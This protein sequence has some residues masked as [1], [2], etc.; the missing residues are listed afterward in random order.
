MNAEALGQEGAS[1]ARKP[2]RVQRTSNSEGPVGPAAGSASAPRSRPRF[3]NPNLSFTPAGWARLVAA[4]ASG[5]RHCG[6]PACSWGPARSSASRISGE[7]AARSSD[8]WSRAIPSGEV[9]KPNRASVPARSMA[10]ADSGGR[11]V[12]QCGH[13]D[14]PGWATAAPQPVHFRTTASTPSGVAITAFDLT[15]RVTV[16]PG[17]VLAV[18]RCSSARAIW[19]NGHSSV[20][21]SG[22]GAPQLGHSTRTGSRGRRA[23]SESGAMIQE[24]HTGPLRR[25][26]YDRAEWA[27]TEAGARATSSGTGRR[28]HPGEVTGHRPSARAAPP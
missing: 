8:C 3:P 22:R 20:A 21:R 15:I 19:Q 24:Y 6:H 7:T 26:P 12:W 11:V 18:D 10:D 27:E 9:G 16:V 2:Q 5:D 28:A 23:S 13:A 4:K 14:A 25:C 1:G 17:A